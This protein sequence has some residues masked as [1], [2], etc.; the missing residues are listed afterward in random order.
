MFVFNLGIIFLE[1]FDQ[2]FKSFNNEYKKKDALI[3][4]Q[5]KLIEERNKSLKSLQERVKQLETKLE[6]ESQSKD[7][8]IKQLKQQLEAQSDQIALLTYQL[9]QLNKVKMNPAHS[10]SLEFTTNLNVND[11]SKSSSAKKKSSI[12]PISEIQPA[13]ERS[14]ETVDYLHSS[15]INKIPMVRARRSSAHSAKSDYSLMENHA[16]IGGASASGL[17]DP[18][19]STL[20]RPSSSNSNP[21]GSTLLTDRSSTPPAHKVLPP[22]IK[23]SSENVPPNVP[24]P[25][26]FLQSAASTLHSRTR[27]ELIQR[28]TLISLPPINKSF[29]LSHLAVE[30]PHKNNNSNKIEHN[31]SS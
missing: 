12:K 26:P 22:V 13:I 18:V 2:K 19:T 14:P 1:E 4:E 20:I 7:S 30:S 9:H 28:R 10:Q 6:S 27:K 3:Q 29:E 8:V 5:K 16:V 17:I 23:R 21:N 15:F 11:S 31:N 25:K 24:D